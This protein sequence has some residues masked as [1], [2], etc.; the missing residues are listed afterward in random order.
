MTCETCGCSYSGWTE[1]LFIHIALNCESCKYTVVGSLVRIWKWA[2][3]ISFKLQLM[4]IFITHVFFMSRFKHMQ[5]RVNAESAAF[6]R[7]DTTTTLLMLQ[8]WL[9]LLPDSLSLSSCIDKMYWWSLF[10]NRMKPENEMEKKKKI[11]LSLLAELVKWSTW[12][13]T[14]DCRLCCIL[15]RGS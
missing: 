10:R 15:K 3:W 6:Y 11:R 14:A 13:R 12:G 4:H 7:W 9:L 8:R 1:R 5:I 2:R